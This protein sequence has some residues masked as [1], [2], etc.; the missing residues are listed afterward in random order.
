MKSSKLL[1]VIVA[2]MTTAALVYFGTGLH[3]IWPLVWYAPIPIIAIAP[4]LRASHVFALG[5]LAWFFGQ[6]NLWKHLAHGIGLPWPLI[7]VSFLIPAIVFTLG[8]LFVR[9][10]LRRGSVFLAA[11]AFP[12]YWVSYE[13]LSASISP[14]STY[15]NLAYTQMNCLPLIQIASLTGI[16]GISFA[17]FL[18]AGATGVLL[19]GA[20][21][22]QQRRTVAIATAVV[23]CAVFLF[24]GWRLRSNPPARSLAVTLIAKDVPMNLYLG[25][26]QQA[27]GLLREYA[28]EIRH[29]TPAGTELIVLPEKVG[30]VSEKVLHAVDAVLK[31]DAE[32]KEASI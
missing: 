30:R 10:F 21:D 28:D 16:W 24:G 8:V 25:S 15:G 2:G 9:S 13:F 26:E 32:R 14:H 12:F 19:S 22:R 20:G 1:L 31:S 29:V 3:P 5:T 6:M 27:L 4:Q 7:V 18:F 17:V 23:L 11:I